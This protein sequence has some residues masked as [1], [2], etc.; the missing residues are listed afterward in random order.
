VESAAA[1]LRLSIGSV[2][3]ARSRIMAR[4]RRKVEQFQPEKFQPGDAAAE[5]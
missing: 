5:G 3:A 1:R 2:Y 4:L